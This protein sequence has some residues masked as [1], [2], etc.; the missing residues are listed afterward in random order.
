MVGRGDEAMMVS[1]LGGPARQGHHNRI[2][3]QLLHFYP[4]LATCFTPDNVGTR[5]EAV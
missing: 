5:G 3:T 1:R 4:G 2:S